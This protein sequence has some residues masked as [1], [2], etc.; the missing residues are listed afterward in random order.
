MNRTRNVPVFKQSSYTFW[1]ETKT[2]QTTRTHSYQHM[3]NFCC[4]QP[5]TVVCFFFFL[6]IC[7]GWKKDHCM[8]LLNVTV[9][10]HWSIKVLHVLAWMLNI[11]N[12]I[13]S[14][15]FSSCQP[16]LCNGKGFFFF[17]SSLQALRQLQHIGWYVGRCLLGYKRSHFPHKHVKYGIANWK[18]TLLRYA[19]AV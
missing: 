10:C 19:T 3:D 18:W 8:L 9:Q 7:L 16:R 2:T 15:R 5:I 6:I 1:H 12:Y 17:F 13:Y 4:G 11:P 14:R